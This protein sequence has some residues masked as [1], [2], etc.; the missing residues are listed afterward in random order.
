[1]VPKRANKLFTGRTRILEKLGHSLAS[2]SP[3]SLVS[4]EQKIF[5]VVGYGGIGKSEVC[6]KF[7]N[8]HRQQ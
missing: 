2:Q 8:D 1:M 3:S 6:L 5:V 4:E 7:A